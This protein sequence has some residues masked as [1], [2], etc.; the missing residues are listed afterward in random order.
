MSSGTL[1]VPGTTVQFGDAAVNDRW[2]S[3][4]QIKAGHWFD[5]QHAWGIE[6]SFFGLQDISTS[7]NASSNGS[8]RPT[9]AGSDRPCRRH[10]NHA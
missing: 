10:S 3:G 4:G 6:G 2:R 5:P 9:S 8:R 1:G 7:F